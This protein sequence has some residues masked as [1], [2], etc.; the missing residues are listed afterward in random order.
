[1]E[2]KNFNTNDIYVGITNYP[3]HREIY[4][5]V[6]KVSG[7]KKYSLNK[8]VKEEEY[9]DNV[10]AYEWY[11]S[12]VK[13]RYY[14]ATSNLLE[15]N[16]TIFNLIKLDVFLTKHKRKLNYTLD[17]TQPINYDEIANL[18]TIINESLTPTRDPLRD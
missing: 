7:I 1:M 11:Q 13:D 16:N 4:D 6:T 8:K 9:G 2:E 18:V 15:S 3:T 17:K 12:I 14:A 5:L 10:I